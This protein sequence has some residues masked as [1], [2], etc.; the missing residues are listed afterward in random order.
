MKLS[1]QSILLVIVTF[2]CIIAVSAVIVTDTA[3]IY[4]DKTFSN[5]LIIS[6]FT[7]VSLFIDLTGIGEEILKEYDS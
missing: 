1:V 6:S 3:T 4:A 7:V 5:L 2:T